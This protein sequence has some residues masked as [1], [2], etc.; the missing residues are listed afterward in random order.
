MET[1]GAKGIYSIETIWF[2]D[3]DDFGTVKPDQTSIRPMLSMFRDSYLRVPVVHR[4]VAT[5]PELE[6]YVKKWCSYPMRYPILHIG[7]HGVR[8][9]V[10][11]YDGTT[12]ELTEIAEWIASTGVSCANCVVHFS[13]C[14]ALYG[15]DTDVF[16]DACGFSAVSGYTKVMYPVWEAWPFEMVYLG[17]LQKRP[18]YRLTPKELRRVKSDLHD[19]YGPALGKLRFALRVKQT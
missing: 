17:L 12:V 4:D 15:T 10:K 3:E 9:G 14:G 6:F 8:H 5:R 1:E 2:E 19:T 13:A 16:L 18:T 7:I 11:L